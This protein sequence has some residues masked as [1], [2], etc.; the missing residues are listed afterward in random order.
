MLFRLSLLKKMGAQERLSTIAR[1][2]QTDV[3]KKETFRERHD[4]KYFL[5]IQSR[6]SF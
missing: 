6:F 4:Y 2:V 3:V 5:P 1:H